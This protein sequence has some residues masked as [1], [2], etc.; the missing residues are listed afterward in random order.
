MLYNMFPIQIVDGVVQS[1]K[2]I[3][4]DASMRVAEYAFKYASQEGRQSVCA[5]H[6]SNIMRASDGLFI[7]CCD[8]VA[9]K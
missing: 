3:T 9:K 8:I 4:R 1:I 6:K 7:Q 2:L 5:V